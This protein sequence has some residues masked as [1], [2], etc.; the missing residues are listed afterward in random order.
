MVHDRA[1]APCKGRSIVLFET[2]VGGLE[3]LGTWDDDDIEPAQVG[4]RVTLSKYFPDQPFSA[5]STDGVS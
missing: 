3:Q 5:I 1:G 2:R 4:R